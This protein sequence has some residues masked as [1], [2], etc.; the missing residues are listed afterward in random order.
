MRRAIFAALLCGVA[1]VAWAEPA[2]PAVATCN[3]ARLGQCFEYRNHTA[4]SLKFSKAACD[5]RVGDEW[6]EGKPCPTEKRFAHCSRDLLGSVTATYFYPPAT[7]A[8]AKE[9]CSA[10][11]LEV[12]TK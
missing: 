12:V 10:L 5:Q 4:D 2:V 1:G 6:S 9:L 8:S 11:A 7:M 3:K